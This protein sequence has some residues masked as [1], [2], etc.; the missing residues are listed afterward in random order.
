MVYLD[1]SKAFDKVD[2]GILL[3]KLRSLGISGNIGIRLYH[4][5][6]NRS[7]IVRLPGGIRKDHP[8]ISG[9]PPGTELG[10]LPFLIMIADNDKDVSASNLISF[11]ND[12]RL[13]SGVGHVTDCDH[14][15]FDQD[16]V[17]DWASSN[18][19]FL[20][21]FFYSYV[22]FSSNG[23]AYKSNVYIDS[24]MNIISPSTHVA[25][26]GISMSSNYNF[27]LHIF[28]LHRRCSHLADW[29]LRTFTM[30]DPH[31]MFTLFK[32]L[33]LSRLDYAS[34]LWCCCLPTPM[35][36]ASGGSP[37]FPLVVHQPASPS[38]WPAVQSLRRGL[39]TNP[40]VTM[41]CVCGCS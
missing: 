31:L 4:F 32:S 38:I 34:Q 39:S 8:V 2:H 36:L 24:S 6:T 41:W 17:Y 25:D 3:H 5:L 16:T 37:M 9:V 10:L 7:H 11:A 19:M 21:R 30:R 27:D 23:V 35:T 40:G 20:T 26:L 13:Y 14:L 29:I 18:N 22:S 1:F 15:Q 28:N 33:V 12:T